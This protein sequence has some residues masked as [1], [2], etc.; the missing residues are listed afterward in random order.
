MERVYTDQ[1][2]ILIP[3]K[4]QA[5]FADMLAKVAGVR[6]VGALLGSNTHYHQLGP[7]ADYVL[8][9]PTLGEALRRGCM[10]LSSIAFNVEVRLVPNGKKCFMAF[11]CDIGSALGKN[12][13]E[14]ATVMQMINLFR[15]YTSPRWT[16]DRVCL[17]AES[18]FNPS[19]KTDVFGAEVSLTEGPPGFWFCS[20]ILTN[21]AI[22]NVEYS[23][24]K[25]LSTEEL[26]RS[27]G[28]SDLSKF[29]NL[30]QNAI[31][32]NLKSSR[33][34]AD[35]IA[36]SIGLGVRTMQRRLMV[37]GE[38][39]QSCLDQARLQRAGELLEQTELTVEEISHHLGYIESNSF[40]RAFRKWHGISHQTT[41][42]TS[43]D[44]VHFEDQA[45]IMRA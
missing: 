31:L 10:A 45:R 13:V 18:D 4:L 44:L 40:R 23:S 38:T 28:Y 21:R 35:Y 27:Y 11:D 1:F 5:Q 14:E 20:S 19:S 3:Y 37:E 26:Q 39:F 43:S 7:Y 36:Q 33:L 8:T 34:S 32:M 25:I 16:P 9:G 6:H 29:S 12:Q 42:R 24:R 41:G 15:C 2:P 17:T 30:V 22:N